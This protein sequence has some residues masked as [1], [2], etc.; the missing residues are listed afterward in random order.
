[1][2]L[3]TFDAENH[4]FTYANAGHN[5]P[6]V[7]HN[8]PD[9]GRGVTWLNPTGPAIG[10]VEE[11]EYSEKTIQLSPGDLLVMYTDGVTEAVNS[12]NEEFGQWRLEA[13][14]KQNIDLPAGEIIKGIRQA[15]GEFTEG[16]PLSDDSTVLIC[17]ISEL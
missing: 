13:L 17:R 4:T 9:E 15:L 5:P 2:V 6:L 11:A 12:K 1:M 3:G 14:V 16:K 10:L 8:A 7:V